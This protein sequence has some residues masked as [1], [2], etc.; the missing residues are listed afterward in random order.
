MYYARSLPYAPKVG[1]SFVG[2]N[3][4]TTKNLDEWWMS[5][6]TGGWS[7]FAFY[8]KI[9]RVKKDLEKV[10]QGVFGDIGRE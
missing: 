1:S 3:G 2:P 4:L 6:H 7:S 5:L 9:K 10:E 8:G